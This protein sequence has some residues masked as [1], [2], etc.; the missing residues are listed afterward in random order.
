MIMFNTLCNNSIHQLLEHQVLKTPEAIAITYQGQYLTY[1]ELNQK[2]NQVAYYLQSFGVKP[3]TLVGICIE[4]S[5]EMLIAMLA[6]LKA[7]GA[8]VPLD[9]SYPADRL[10]FM[11]KDSGLPILLTEPSQLAKLSHSSARQIV[12]EHDRAEIDRQ[13]QDNVV[14]SVTAKNVA[15]IIYTSGSTGKPKGVEVLHGAGVNLLTAM[16]QT[17]GLTAADTLLAVTTISFDL[18]VVDLFL[19]LSVGAKIALVSREVAADPVLLAQMITESGATL[20]Q[21]TPATWRLLL[22]NNWQGNSD[23]NIICGGEA[24]TRSLADL[25]LERCKSLWNMYGPTETTVYSAVYR[26]EPGSSTIPIGDPIANTQIY[27][28]DTQ[29]QHQDHVL[30]QVAAGQPG[31][32]YIGGYGLARGYLNRPE[33]TAE[34]FV[35]DPFSD[36]P[37]AR[38]YR[39]GDLAHLLP[40]GKIQFLDRVDRQVKIRGYRIELGAI[41]AVIS[42]YPEVKEAAVII[43][44]DNVGEK[45]LVAYVGFKHNQNLTSR[46]REYLNEKLPQYMVPSAFV[47][48]DLFPLTPNGKIDRRALPIVNLERPIL[49]VELVKPRNTIE[50]Q[51]TNLW[52]QLLGIQPIGIYDNFF[53]LGGHSLFVANMMTQVEET[54]AV[55]LTLTELFITPTIADLAESIATARQPQSVAKSNFA[56]LLADAELDPSIVPAEPGIDRLQIP[57]HIFLTGATGFLGAFLLD[58]LLRSTNA[59]IYCL[60]RSPGIEVGHQKL[61]HNLERYGLNPADY[62]SRVIPVIGDLSQPLLGMSAAEFRQLAGTIDTIYHNGAVVNLVYPY[63]LMRNTNVKGTEE[64]LRLASQVKV[65]PVH[66]IS[67]LDI[68]QSAYH[69]RLDTRLEDDQFPASAI[70]NSGYAQTKWVAEKLVKAAHARG[71]PTCIHRPGMIIGHSQ[72]GCSNTEDQISRLIKGLIQLGSAPAIDLPMHLT[73]VDY[74]SQAIVKLAGQQ[75]AWGKAFHLS[76]PQPLSM[77]EL[78]DYLKSL[79]YEIRSTDY[80]RWLNHLLES[81]ISP[82]NVLKPL[83]PLFTSSS[84]SYS[85]YLEVL[86][87]E[88]VSCQNIEAELA[89]TSISCPVLDAKLLDIYF[90]Y[91]RHSG[92]LDRKMSGVAESST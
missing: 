6:V 45:Q 18:S 89:G 40:D 67:T 44:E 53:E 84:A 81:D 65:K 15:Y 77:L 10:A 47:M 52:S 64:I 38:L 49:D 85:T 35:P 7:G 88:N 80:D 59:K 39:T 70:P 22:A 69:S 43:R 12:L 5:L 26:V 75:S 86:S 72:T 30:K 36:Q 56:Q 74:V 87:L 50:Q 19:P 46:L 23:L 21:A 16:S 76:N 28:I 66:L 90:A 24:M 51:L 42:Q 27:L 2:A 32:I 29:C 14:N 61:R 8:Y 17:P 54:F 31:E 68:F 13:S 63:E 11:I 57:Q 55:K 37:D 41:E 25:L 92:F 34:R 3:E 62:S 9:P 79:H 83:V 91:F 1:R 33:I 20:M 71:I 78:V 4:R 60:I 58:E 73:P 82:A 48:M